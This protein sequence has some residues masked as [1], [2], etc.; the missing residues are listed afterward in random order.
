MNDFPDNLD[1]R[2]AEGERKIS[3]ARL[4]TDLALLKMKLFQMGLSL[5]T[6]DYEEYRNLEA[7]IKEMEGESGNGQ[8]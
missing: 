4:K 5:K 6:S 7:R 3:E 8:R 1:E 2:I